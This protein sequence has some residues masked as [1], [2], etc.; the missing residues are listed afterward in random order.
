LSSTQQANHHNVKPADEDAGQPRNRV[1]ERHMIKEPT[2]SVF[3]FRQGAER[4]WLAALVWHP[5]LQCWLPAGGHVEND[6]TAAEAA[7]REALE[8]SSL[9]ITLIPGP[10]VPLPAGFP[11]QPVPAPWWVTEATAAFSELTAFVPA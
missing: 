8:E 10:A 5:R 11:H 2:A 3:I 4:G 1:F 7:V 9:D 6:E